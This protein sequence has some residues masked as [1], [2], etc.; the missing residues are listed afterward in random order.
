MDSRPRIELRNSDIPPDIIIKSIKADNNL[1]LSPCNANQNSLKE[2]NNPVTM[3]RI[4]KVPI[5]NRQ[6][7]PIEISI[8]LNIK[9]GYL[10]KRFKLP[11]FKHTWILFR[12][13][14]YSSFSILD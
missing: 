10:T 14:T 1:N 5:K 8:V 13:L 2:R 11:A 9:F 7:G 12:K 4:P 3:T 6:I